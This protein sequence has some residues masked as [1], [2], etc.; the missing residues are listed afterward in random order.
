VPLRR[1]PDPGDLVGPVPDLL[2]GMT[3]AQMDALFGGSYRGSLLP[4]DAR[5]VAGLSGGWI[6]SPAPAA[7]VFPPLYDMTGEGESPMPTEGTTV[8]EITG[9]RLRIEPGQTRVLLRSNL[10]TLDT[11]TTPDGLFFSVSGVQRGFFAHR[12]APTSPISGFT[13]AE[14]DGG[15]IRFVHDGSLVAPTYTVTVT[16]GTT[17]TVPSTVVVDFAP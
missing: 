6:G 2:V 8:P 13:Q 14:L 17:T 10:N 11:D 12:D 9:N 3:N 5:R 7:T 1:A 16:D 4:G 15:V